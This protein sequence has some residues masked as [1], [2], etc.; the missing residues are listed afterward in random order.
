MIE[1]YK[2]VII[3]VIVVTILIV[4]EIILL[5]YKKMPQTVVKNLPEHVQ[6][7]IRLK[8]SFLAFGDINLGRT[9]GQKIL[10]DWSR[11]SIR[12]V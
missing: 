6:Q 7:P 2:K 4:T 9:V 12:E 10:K 8:V 5:S 11:L 1:N 3:V